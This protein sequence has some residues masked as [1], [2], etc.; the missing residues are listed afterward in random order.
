VQKQLLSHKKNCFAFVFNDQK[1][2]TRQCTCTYVC[3]P[4]GAAVAQR[5]SD[6]KLNENLKDPSFAPFL[7]RYVDT[8]YNWNRPPHTQFRT[9]YSLKVSDHRYKINTYTFYSDSSTSI[10][11][12]EFFCK[13]ILLTTSFRQYKNV[14][15]QHDK[16]KTTP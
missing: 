3:R 5:W 2:Q 10:S 4:W 8:R 15:V 9:T 16:Q 7:K 14:I 11:V 13:R 1:G 6:V 12:Y